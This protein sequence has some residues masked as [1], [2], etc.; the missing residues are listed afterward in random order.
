M[1][2][3]AEGIRG[4][5]AYLENIMNLYEPVKPVVTTDPTVSMVVKMPKSQREAW[6]AH[7]ESHD[8]EMSE[9]IRRFIASE[10]SKGGA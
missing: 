2:A 4:N 8:I 1:N 3:L 7:C 6:K 5:F 9:V 10:L